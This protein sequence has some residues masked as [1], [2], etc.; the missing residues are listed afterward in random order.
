MLTKKSQIDTDLT[1]L[2]TMVLAAIQSGECMQ[3][4]ICLLGSQIGASSRGRAAF[5]LVDKLVPES[6]QGNQYFVTLKKALRG[7]ETFCDRFRCRL[8]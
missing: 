3:R 4:S 5:T 8:N 1:E 6:V 7:G 2:A